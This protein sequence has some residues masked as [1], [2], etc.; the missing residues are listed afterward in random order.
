MQIRCRSGCASIDVLPGFGV[1]ERVG[2]EAVRSLRYNDKGPD[3]AGPLKENWS[4]A[5]L[6]F[7]VKLWHQPLESPALA[8][9]RGTE[10]RHVGVGH[11]GGLHVTRQQAHD[12]RCRALVRHLREADAGAVTQVGGHVRNG[13]APAL[14]IVTL[15]GLAL[16]EARDSSI[17]LHG[18]SARTV[19]DEGSS[20]KRAMA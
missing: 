10:F 2:G 12:G 19:T 3:G 8:H 4:N 11:G 14:E 7:Q 1:S 16:A 15:A 17:V 13:A 20:V 6:I 5:G 18:T 9:D